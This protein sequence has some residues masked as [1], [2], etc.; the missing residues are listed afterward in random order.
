MLIALAAADDGTIYRKRRSP[1]DARNWLKQDASERE[2]VPPG[3]APHY[4]AGW[5]AYQEARLSMM[6]LL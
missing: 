6:A 3:K 5:L 4:F 1:T 2:R